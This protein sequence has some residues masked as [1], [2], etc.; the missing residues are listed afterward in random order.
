MPGA[1][2]ARGFPTLR[3]VLTRQMEF[4]CVMRGADAKGGG[5]GGGDCECHEGAPR[6]RRCAR[7]GHVSAINLHARYAMSSTGL[8]FAVVSAYAMSRLDLGALAGGSALQYPGL[9]WRLCWQ[10]THGMCRL[11]LTWVLGADRGADRVLSGTD[12]RCGCWALSNLPVNNLDNLR[13]IPRTG[14]IQAILTG[15]SLARSLARS[16]VLDPACGFVGLWSLVACV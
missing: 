14:G 7:A 12:M 11:Q 1:G 13:S 9:S 6:A 5:R 2:T 10:G 3:A 8:A 4:C 15:S 16:C